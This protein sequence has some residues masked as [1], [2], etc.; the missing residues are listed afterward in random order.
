WQGWPRVKIRVPDGA[1]KGP[2]EEGSPPSR[3]VEAI[4]PLIISASRSTDIPAF[5]GDWFMDRLGKGYAKWINPW[6]GIPMYVSFGD[7]RVFVFWSKNPEPFLPHLAELERLGNRYL[8]LFTLNDYEAERAEPNIP[9]LEDRIRTFQAIS[10]MAGKGRVAWRWDPLLLSGSLGVKGLLDRIGRVGD[11]IAPFTDR[12]IISFIDIARYPRVA[13][14]LRNRGFGDIREFSPAEERELATGLQELNRSWG[15]T[16]SACG[17]KRDL[18]RFGIGAG[19]CIS[20]EVLLREFA[21]DPVLGRFLDVPD[22]GTP[23][24][25]RETSPVPPHLKDPGQRRACGC[26]VS[27][28]IGQYATCPHLCAYCYANTAPARVMGRYEAYR[29]D[30]RMGVFGE[31]I[32][33]EKKKD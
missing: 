30:A 11:A 13:R 15:L 1:Q 26:V 29:A 10:R 3:A 25:S 12:M 24:G 27:K 28:D 9:P 22:Q 6:N 8:V 32:T 4:A 16:I 20:R 7:A 21:G 18:S 17:E 5:Y 19:N 31:S 2:G 14:L 33:E 23:S